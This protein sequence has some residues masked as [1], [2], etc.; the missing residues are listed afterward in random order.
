MVFS[1]DGTKLFTGGRK[2]PEIICWDLRNPGTVLFILNRTVLT[3]QRI[4]FDITP[5]GQYVFSGK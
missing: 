4:Y 1:P 3:N 2:D 5:N